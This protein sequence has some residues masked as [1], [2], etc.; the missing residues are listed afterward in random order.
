MESNDFRKHVLDVYNRFA[1]LYDTTEFFRRES[2]EMAVRASGVMPGERVLDVCT[3]TGELALA[4]ARAGARAAAIDLARGM[5]RVC[6]HKA[7]GSPLHMLET[8]ATCLPFGDN[9]F[10]IVTLSLGLHHM[11]EAAQLQVM[12]EMTRLARRRVVFIEWHAPRNP[13]WR[14]PW[15]RLIK[16]M[17]E[18]E[19]IQHWVHQDFPATC[20][21]AGL[22]V[23]DERVSTHKFHRITVCKP[24]FSS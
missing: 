17:D 22:Q 13:R 5:L 23:E 2:R 8:D 14:T 18:S 24:V 16:L 12:S 11:P 19:Y 15:G 3:G 4:F 20:Q 9:A 6:K 7:N 1:W 21:K 10:D